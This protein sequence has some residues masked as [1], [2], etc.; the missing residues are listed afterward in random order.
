MFTRN[1][2]NRSLTRNNISGNFGKFEWNLSKAAN[3]D[4]STLLMI[5]VAVWC[6]GY[7]YCTTSFNQ[8]WTQVF[9][10][11]KPCWRRVRE[12]RWWGSLTMFPAE[13]KAKWLSSANHSAKTIHHHHATTDVF[14]KHFQNFQNRLF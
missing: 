3:R 9:R 14:W 5:D 11:F 10:R 1:Y 4:L 6:F 12:S 8:A 7:P 13:N 2:S